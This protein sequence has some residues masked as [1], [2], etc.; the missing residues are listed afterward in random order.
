MTI[1]SKPQ[2]GIP[3]KEAGAQVHRSFS[4]KTEIERGIV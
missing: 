1:H 4:G 2:A 3:I